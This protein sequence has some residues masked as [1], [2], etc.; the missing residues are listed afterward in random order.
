MWLVFQSLVIFAVVAS[1]IHWQWTPN[2]YVATALGVGVAYLATLGLN[3]L[4]ATR[5]EKRRSQRGY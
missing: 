3:W 1:N 2:G 4:L 5:A